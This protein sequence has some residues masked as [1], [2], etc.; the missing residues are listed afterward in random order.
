LPLRD[1]RFPDRAAWSLLRQTRSRVRIGELELRWISPAPDGSLRLSVSVRKKNGTA[2]LRNR[3]KRQLREIV[4]L[5]RG[6]LG[7]IWLQWSLPP[8]RLES[9][10]VSLRESALASLERAGLVRP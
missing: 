5:R 1:I 10:T 8:K 4:R 7:T 3:I 9:S 6:E 2:P